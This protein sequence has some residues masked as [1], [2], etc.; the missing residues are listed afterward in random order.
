[1]VKGD[2]GGLVVCYCFLRLYLSPSIPN[3]KSTSLTERPRALADVL[4][5]GSPSEAKVMQMNK[6][7]FSL[8][9]ADKI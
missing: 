7:D 6:R 9:L 5:H 8:R 2:Y 4:T 3:P 1:M